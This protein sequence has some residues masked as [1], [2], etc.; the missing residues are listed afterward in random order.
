MKKDRRPKK[1]KGPASSSLAQQKTTDFS[2]NAFARFRSGG[3]HETEVLQ[4]RNTP[5]LIQI[6]DERLKT[7]FKHLKKKDPTTRLKALNSIS[8]LL[9]EKK[10]D[11]MITILPEWVCSG[12]LRHG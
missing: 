4:F 10:K 9:G 2:Q 5:T 11:E 1:E 8:E 12:Q 7:H 3:F 6:E